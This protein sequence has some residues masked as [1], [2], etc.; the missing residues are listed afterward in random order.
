MAINFCNT[1]TMFPVDPDEAHQ[2]TNIFECAECQNRVHLNEYSNEY[3]YKFCPC[4]GKT[5]ENIKDYRM[6]KSFAQGAWNCTFEEYKS[7]QC[8][9]CNEKNCLHRGAYRRVPKLDG[10]LALCSRLQ[11]LYI[12]NPTNKTF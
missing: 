3:T 12:Q 10:G 8:S 7:F 5:V 1:T 9:D 4:C 11:A 2:V 6:R